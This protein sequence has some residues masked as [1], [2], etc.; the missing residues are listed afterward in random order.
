LTSA[1]IFSELRVALKA[2]HYRDLSYEEKS[3]YKNAFRNGYKLAKKHNKKI[4][5]Y[6]RAKEHTVKNKDTYLNKPHKGMIDSLINKVCIRLEVPK[7][8]VLGKCRKGHLIQARTLIHNVLR[9]KYKMSLPMIGDYFNQDH[10]TVLNS[11][12]MKQDKRRF[13]KDNETIWKDFESLLND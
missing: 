3:I 5:H 4:I 13:W 2:G 1:Q 7:D 10:T 6:I 12:Q 8:Q 9:E 11:V